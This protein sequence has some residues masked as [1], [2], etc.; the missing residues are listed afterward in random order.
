VETHADRCHRPSG[1]QVVRWEEHGARHAALWR[2]ATSARPPRR[3]A[4]VADDLS[5]DRALRRARSGTALLWRGD[6]RGARQLL[7]AMKR[8]LAR[9]EGAQ[10]REPAAAFRSHR[11]AV[12]ERARLLGML[13]VE[14]DEEHRILAAHAPDVRQ[15]CE[16]DYGPAGEPSVVAL[17]ELLGVVGASQWRR[18]GIDVAALGA[19]IHP[20]HGV[21]APTRQDYVELV[22]RAPLPAVDLA[23][24]VGTGTG[25][26]AAVLGHRGVARV[27]ATDISPAAV[28]CAQEN[29]ARL[30]LAERVT[31]RHAD[32]F[33]PGRAGLVVCNPPWLPGRPTS[34][35]EAGVYDEEGRMLR[36]VIG[37][38]PDHLADG[39]EAWLVLSD[40]A[41]LFGLRS[42]GDLLGL[43][44]G[45]GLT[46]RDRVDAPRRTSRAGTDALGA[47]RARE[48]ITLWILARR[49]E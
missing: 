14:L 24:D 10:E 33:P 26:L 34:T 32:L 47:L 39:G 17:Q 36:G 37:G 18:R 28:A 30:G 42:R 35:L 7:D 41:E 43:V 45:A 38:L 48:T 40:L 5:A 2:S 25:V 23:F 21:F 29:V 27:V 15:A 3:V 49:D 19:R 12:A 8:R 13:L 31:V 22:A 11:R 4:V 16:G 1:H 6:H 46:V 20:H 9:L 44:A